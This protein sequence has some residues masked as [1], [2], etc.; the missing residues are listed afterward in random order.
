MILKQGLKKLEH[1]L[2]ENQSNT[3]MPLT[4]NPSLK[5]KT[6]LFSVKNLMQSQQLLMSQQYHKGSDVML[7]AHVE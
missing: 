7:S 2:Q 4:L 6:V 5:G 3:K 1:H